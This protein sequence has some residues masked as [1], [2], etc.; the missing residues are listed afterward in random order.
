MTS[1]WTVAGRVILLEVRHSRSFLGEPRVEVVG[2][3]PKRW[4]QGSLQLETHTLQH[5]PRMVWH[6]PARSQR[7]KRCADDAQLH[8]TA[9]GDREIGAVAEVL[10]NATS[11]SIHFNQ[12]LTTNVAANLIFAASV[13]DGTHSLYYIFSDRATQQTITTYATNTT[14]VIPTQKLQWNSIAL[15][16]QLIWNA[17]GWATPPQVT[18]TVFLESNSPGVYYTTLESF[19]PA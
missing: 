7:D 12:S 9:R 6:Q 2:S 14:V 10:L 3:G 16:P 18:F 5:E 19:S 17:Q 1:Y 11:L 15:N 13:V 8:F 4:D